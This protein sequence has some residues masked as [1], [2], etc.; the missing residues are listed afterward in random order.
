MATTWKQEEIRPC[1]RTTTSWRTP[2]AS[3]SPSTTRLR[4]SSAISLPLLFP[5]AADAPLSLPRLL[6]GTG[7]T[8]YMA[9]PPNNYPFYNDDER[10]Q[11]VVQPDGGQLDRSPYQPSR[12]RRR[13]TGGR[14]TNPACPTGTSLADSATR[15]CLPSEDG[16]RAGE[17]SVF[18]PP[19][20]TFLTMSTA[21]TT[22]TSTP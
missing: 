15:G 11:L 6:T 22:T 7:R 17:S 16:E 5:T 10:Y 9:I 14:P 19:A 12:S 8:G 20:S 1:G 3:P 2:R 13:R 21:T 4:K 18:L